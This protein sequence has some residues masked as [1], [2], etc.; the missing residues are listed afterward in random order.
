MKG[1]FVVSALVALLLALSAYGADSLSLRPA[2]KPGLLKNQSTVIDPDKSAF[3]IPFGSSE[4]KV[5]S[6]FGDPNGVFVIN[7]STKA[8]LYGKATVF[9]FKGNKLRELYLTRSVVEWAISEK[10]EGNPFFDGNKWVFGNGIVEGMS[11]P[12]I[13]KRIG[14]PNARPD[15]HLSYESEAAVTEFTFSESVDSG[16]D[17][18]DR[19]S[20]LGITVKNYGK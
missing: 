7:E 11:F 17:K 9:V 12:E 13:A 2:Y 15:Y 4:S 19:F 14:K 3:G 18:A 5:T 1:Q 20:L 6:A 8:L 16:R 10:M